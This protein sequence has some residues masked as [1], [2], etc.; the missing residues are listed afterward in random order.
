MAQDKT[1]LDTVLD[2]ASA[3]ETAAVFPYRE[4]EGGKPSD[5]YKVPANTRW[6]LI[7]AHGGSGGYS[8]GGESGGPGEA[9][10]SGALSPSSR[11]KHSASTRGM[12]RFMDGKAGRDIGQ[13]ATAAR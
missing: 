8:T 11:A 5:T 10:S 7:E 12:G 2:N 4:R 3:P 6:I 13:E 1:V 9:A